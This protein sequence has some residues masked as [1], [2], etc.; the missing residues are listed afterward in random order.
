MENAITAFAGTDQEGKIIITNANILIASGEVEAALNNLSSISDSQK[1]Y[2]ETKK[3]MADIYLTVL[4]DRQSYARCYKEIVDA[5]PNLSSFL[6]LGDAYI[7]IE[8]PELSVDVYK[9]ALEVFPRELSLH[10]K[11]G[12]ALI[13][14]HNY[15]RVS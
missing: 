14:T 10:G 7:K 2:I 8:E 12:K 3:A 15:K 1:Y 5:E 4:N 9:T 6:L 11:I 13:K